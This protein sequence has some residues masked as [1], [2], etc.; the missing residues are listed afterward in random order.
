[1]ATSQSYNQLAGLAPEALPEKVTS[2]VK[3]LYEARQ[4]P[5]LDL[6]PAELRLLINRHDPP[7]FPLIP[8]LVEQAYGLLSQNL[9]IE[10]DYYPGDLIYTVLKLPEAF[11]HK[12][13][14]LH[15]KYIALMQQRRPTLDRL[16]EGA[17]KR[18]LPEMADKFLAAAK[19]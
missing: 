5:L 18:D 14:E 13:P 11:W 17:M 6:T 15:G 4:K 8:E 2:V 3:R 12:H 1:M 9:L 7:Q 10:A 19:G 16:L